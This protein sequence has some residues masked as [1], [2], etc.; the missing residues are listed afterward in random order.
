MMVKCVNCLWFDRESRECIALGRHIMIPEVPRICKLYNL[1][2][3]TVVNF[4]EGMKDFAGVAEPDS[5]G[6]KNYLRKHRLVR[7]RK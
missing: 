5:K 3:E 4:I 6:V 7:W 2:P 1:V